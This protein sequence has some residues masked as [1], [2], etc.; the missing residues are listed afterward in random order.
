MLV[1]CDNY[2]VS[3]CFSVISITILLLCFQHLKLPPNTFL[4]PFVGI[5]SYIRIRDPT[6]QNESNRIVD[7]NKMYCNC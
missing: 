2:S 1:L 3:K 6:I 5:K 7:Q 4:N